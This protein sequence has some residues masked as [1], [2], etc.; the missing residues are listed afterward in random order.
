MNWQPSYWTRDQMEERRLEGGRLLKAGQLSQ[1]AIARQLGVSRTAVSIWAKQVTLT[2]VRGLR[3]KRA[4]GSACKLTKAQQQTLKR[5]LDRGALAAGYATDRWTL[6]RVGEVIQ[7]EFAIGYHPNYLNRLLD[8]LG[9][10]LQTPLPQALEQ[11]QAAVR[12]WRKTDWPRIKKGS[13]ARGYHRLS[14]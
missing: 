2:G 3:R 6:G 11:D 9:Y 5:L 14:R 12:A 7:R 1:A 10:S 8:R 13:A 4:P